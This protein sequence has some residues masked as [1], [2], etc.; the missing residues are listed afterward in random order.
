MPNNTQKGNQ[1]EQL[2]IAYLNTQ[3]YLILDRNWRYKHLELDIVALFQ[4]TL[5]IVEVKWRSTL[6]FGAPETFVTKAKQKNLIKAADY[7]IKTKQLSYEARFDIV[8]I[9]QTSFEPKI[10]HLINAFYPL[11]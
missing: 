5:V 3:G 11:L 9:S 6:Y 4:N 8:S 2:A 10:E 1:G 7:Y